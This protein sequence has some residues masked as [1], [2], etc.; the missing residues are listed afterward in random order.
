[1][2]QRMNQ[3]ICDS[4]WW[5]GMIGL[6]DERA[7]RLDSGG[8]YVARLVTA[9]GRADPAAARHEL[10]GTRRDLLRLRGGYAAVTR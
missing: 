6:V 1:M 3:I 4:V 10:E 2:N 5:A 9:E 8:G 7:V